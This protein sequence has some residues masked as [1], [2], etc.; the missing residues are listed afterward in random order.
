MKKFLYILLF[1]V[2]GT[3][4]AAEIPECNA[5]TVG[6]VQCISLKE[7]SC[8]LFRTS[9]INNDAG[10]YRWDCGITRP[11]CIDQNKISDREDARPYS[12]PDSVFIQ[13]K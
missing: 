2:A 10:G 7:C 6:M 4:S 5:K 12:G 9:L 11:Q 1:F 13:Q 3:A 8:K